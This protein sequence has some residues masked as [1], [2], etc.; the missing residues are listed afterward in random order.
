MSQAELGRLAGVTQSVISAYESGTR[1][2]SLP[3]LARI[4]RATGAEL[5]VRVL[6]DAAPPI[7][8]PQPRGTLARRVRDHRNTILAVLGRH[9]L[10]NPRLIGS[11]AR[12]EEKPGSD[13]DL[14]VDIP[15]GIGLVTLAR[16]QAELEAL[17]GAPVDIVPAAD[18]KPDVA[19]SVL[20]GAVAL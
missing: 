7:R 8:D 18:L 14:L 17:L 19:A 2:P 6:Y 1:Q 16:C 15:A 13:V 10:T 12:G 3:T 4:I 11:V 5:D 20:A 9:R